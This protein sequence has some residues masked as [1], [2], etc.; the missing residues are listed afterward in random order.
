M[1]DEL[2]VLDSIEDTRTRLG[3]LGRTKVYALIKDGELA[4]VKI[5]RRAF[6][7]RRS[8]DAYVERLLE[9]RA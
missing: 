2:K 3:N 5:G 7:T 6:V 4:T 1:H 9:A 8:T